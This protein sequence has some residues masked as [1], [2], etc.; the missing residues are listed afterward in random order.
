[1]SWTALLQ[2]PFH[3]GS[4][5]SFGAEPIAISWSPF[6]KDRSS[7]VA[8]SIF[9]LPHS[10]SQT[11]VSQSSY[12][13]QSESPSITPV[14]IDRFTV[15]EPSVAALKAGIQSVFE[16][17]NS[18]AGDAT[19]YLLINA[20]GYGNYLIDKDGNPF[21]HRELVEL[22]H[23]KMTEFEK[24]H[25]SKITVKLFLNSCHGFSIQQIQRVFSNSS[26]YSHSQS[27]PKLTLEIFAASQPKYVANGALFW[28]QIQF[29]SDLNKRLEGPVTIQF[30]PEIFLSLSSM[31][32]YDYFNSQT[33]S[34]VPKKIRLP[35]IEL[36][37]IVRN[38]HPHFKF[39][40][41]HDRY[42]AALMLGGAKERQAV[43]AAQAL[44][45]IGIAIQKKSAPTHFDGGLVGF[46]VDTFGEIQLLSYIITGLSHLYNTEL[47][48]EYPKEF[49]T[50]LTQI[51]SNPLPPGTPDSALMAL[52]KHKSSSD[53]FNV[54]VNFMDG[55]FPRTGPNSLNR[56][57]ILPALSESLIA[58]LGEDLSAPDLHVG[59]QYFA[60]QSFFYSRD[61]LAFPWLKLALG[62]DYDADIRK[63][64]I[65]AIQQQRTVDA[66]TELMTLASSQAE[67]EMIR[68][69]AI[70]ALSYYDSPE[71]IALLRTLTL[72]SNTAV[73]SQAK[74]VLKFFNLE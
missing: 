43:Q 46:H 51:I 73:S 19:L 65:V 69:T 47:D 41:F 6:D 62:A 35:L 52:L 42:M 74:V 67:S 33:G 1:M 68:K 27:S 31:N 44:L 23:Q 72:D 17:V 24:I 61:V 45:K 60:I 50:L 36:I 3:L 11:A 18:E 38:E 14:L 37:S 28:E 30:S 64:A 57:R 15:I 71:V 39:K 20:H 63:N 32:H 25:E 34:A 9:V 13:V 40:I 22:L 10:S 16:K 4:V 66:Q 53:S 26:D 7:E 58:K 56:D 70:Q 12:Q 2:A 48:G 55:R 54:F 5:S 21:F 8:K 29:I 59:N 49:I